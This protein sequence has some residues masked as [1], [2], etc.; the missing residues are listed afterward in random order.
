MQAFKSTQ[1]NAWKV[2]LDLRLV[3]MKTKV[4]QLMFNPW[5]HIEWLPFFCFICGVLGL[6]ETECLWHF[7]G[8]TRKSNDLRGFLRNIMLLAEVGWRRKEWWRA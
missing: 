6:G 1:R 5:F 3:D 8:R 7:G 2:G 4:F